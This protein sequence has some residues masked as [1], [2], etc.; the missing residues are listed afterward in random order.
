MSERKQRQDDERGQKPAKPISARERWRMLLELEAWL[1]TPM[2]I[3]SLAWLA[4]V[5]VELAWAPSRFFTGLGLAIWGI[6]I[7]EFALRFFLAPGK[8]AFL[9]RNPITLIALAAPAFRFLTML[10]MLRVLR[11]ARGLRLVRVIGT[12][13]RGLK[14]L[15]KSFGRRGLG[16]VVAA[17]VA[18]TLLG[19][20]GMLSLEPSSEVPG[21]FVD[22]GHALWW[23]A[24]V[25]ATMGS[26]FWPRTGEGRLLCLLLTI[27]GFTIFGYIAASLAAFFIEQESKAKDS[28]VAGASEM[29]ALRAE[30]AALRAE[31]LADRYGGR[32]DG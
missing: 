23:T 4:L 14:A 7:V 13:N 32:R 19:A 20:A 29:A 2:Q 17:T 3:L 18:V 27:Y 21:G 25:V 10:R 9:K 6:F 28:N 22:F 11:F 5:V 31:L 12:A 16:Y 24:M 30:I 8:W 1:E 26:D 15:S